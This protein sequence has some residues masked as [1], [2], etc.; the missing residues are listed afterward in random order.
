MKIR[1]TLATHAG[2]LDNAMVVLPDDADSFEISN[3]VQEVIDSW[4][5]GVGDVITIRAA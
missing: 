5:I 2:D 4:I 1:V 3:A